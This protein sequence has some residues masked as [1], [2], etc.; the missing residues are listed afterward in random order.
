M[1]IVMGK[2]SSHYF[3]IEMIFHFIFRRTRS[4]FIH[5]THV[6]IELSYI[7][8]LD[9][10]WLTFTIELTISQL[11]TRYFI[12]YSM[13]GSYDFILEPGMQHYNHHDFSGSKPHFRSS[14][15]TV[16]PCFLLSS[17]TRS[18]SL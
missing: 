14:N 7:Y 2:K 6:D 1:M 12:V 9:L 15:C 16:Y 5:I 10:Y 4:A 13:H 3:Q 8:N 17:A 18:L 11:V